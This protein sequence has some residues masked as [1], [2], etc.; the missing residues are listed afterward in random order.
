M[1]SN[2]KT[3][4]LLTSS[5]NIID[6]IPSDYSIILRLD[7]SSPIEFN[8]YSIPSLSDAILINSINS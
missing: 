6:G 7:T 5:I 2:S 4:K 1:V 8:S 3:S